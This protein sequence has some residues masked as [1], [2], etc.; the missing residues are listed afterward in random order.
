M[1][2]VVERQEITERIHRKVRR[3]QRII[4]RKR[5]AAC[6]ELRMVF[7]A[8]EVIRAGFF[9]LP[10]Q[11]VDILRILLLRVLTAAEQILQTD[12]VAQLRIAIISQCRLHCTA[13]GAVYRSICIRRIDCSAR[14][15]HSGF[16]R[17][18]IRSDVVAEIAA[19]R[20]RHS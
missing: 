16:T 18:K 14:I 8:V 6:I 3:E 12:S 9:I 13:D 1:D 2:D 4:Q 15:G 10:E 11:A 7:A 5:I 20:V 17:S 19:R